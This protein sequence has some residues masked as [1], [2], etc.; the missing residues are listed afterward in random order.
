MA[1]SRSEQG[2][3]SQSGPAQ[4]LQARASQVPQP[5][6]P[7]SRQSSVNDNACQRSTKKLSMRSQATLTVS[8]PDDKREDAE[9]S[10]Y[11]PLW[12]QACASLRAAQSKHVRVK[13][14]FP[15]SAHPCSPSC[16]W[17]IVCVEP[18]FHGSIQYGSRGGN[19]RY[20]FSDIYFRA[21]SRNPAHLAR[22]FVALLETQRALMPC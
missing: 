6:Q 5:A 18:S 10:L 2:Q 12:D 11:V 8:T 22:L 20:S 13:L 7:V 9:G 1:Q 17:F 19:W 15:F 14:K 16:F 3:A 4:T 21:F